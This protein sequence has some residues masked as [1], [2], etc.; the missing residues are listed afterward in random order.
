MGIAKPDMWQYPALA[1]QREEDCEFNQL[2][3]VA[4]LR[5]AQVV[6]S[7]KLAQAIRKHCAFSAVGFDFSGGAIPQA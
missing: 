2:W 7:L 3:V 5:L 6:A 1:R 4:S